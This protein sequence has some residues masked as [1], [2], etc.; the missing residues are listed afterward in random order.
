MKSIEIDYKY[1]Y[2]I[3]ELNNSARNNEGTPIIRRHYE[4]IKMIYEKRY[5]NEKI[6]TAYFTYFKNDDKI[7][8]EVEKLLK[9]TYVE[10]ENYII[11]NINIS[12]KNDF[13]DNDLMLKIFDLIQI[14]GGIPGGGGPYQRRKRKNGELG[15]PWRSLNYLEWIIIYKEAAKLA[16]IGDLNA[17]SKFQEIKHLGGL[18]FASKHAYFFS[19]HLNIKSLII[20]DVKIA[21]CFKTEK[22]N[23]LN[24]LNINGILKYITKIALKNNLNRWQIEKALFTFHLINFYNNKI[25]KNTDT[26]KLKDLKAI[27]ELE[28]WYKT[29]QTPTNEKNN[30]ISEGEIKNDNNIKHEVIGSK[31]KIY[32]VTNYSGIYSC[33]CSAFK[34]NP[35]KDCKHILS[36]KNNIL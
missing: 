5:L 14:W 3:S 9:F 31:G 16:S 11:E 6:K 20:I 7:K 1:W 27:K 29:F 25:I 33:D 10:L 34:Y 17:Y 2:N 32:T 15:S 30:F 23:D 36:K 28:N 4:V 18:A 26:N 24:N 13:K 22:A 12:R 35:N 19:K 21:H 8:N